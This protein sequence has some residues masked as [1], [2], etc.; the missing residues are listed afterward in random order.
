M[1]IFFA[2]FNMGGGQANWRMAPLLFA[3][4]LLLNALPLLANSG[5]SQLLF[6][7]ASLPFSVIATLLEGR[8]PRALDVAAAAVVCIA[9]SL[10]FLLLCM[11]RQRGVLFRLRRLFLEGLQGGGQGQQGGGGG[12][13][14]RSHAE[15]LEMAAK[16]LQGLPLETYQTKEE[17]MQMPAAKLRTLAT[18]RGV[19]AAGAVEKAELAEAIA[20][21]GNSTGARCSVCCEDYASGDLLRV[22]RCNHRFHCECIDRWLLASTD[23]SRPPA[24]PMCSAELS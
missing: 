8:A 23:Y 20:A 6:G 16:A 21:G 3:A 19:D 15:R 7:A 9:L 11:M 10:L 18:E 17:L 14:P 1:I 12:G 22:L 13:R 24:C 2:N 4:P 5:L